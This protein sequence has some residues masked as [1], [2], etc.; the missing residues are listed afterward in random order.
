[1]PER[2]RSIFGLPPVLGKF[3]SPAT[4][5]RLGVGLGDHVHTRVRAVPMG[6]SWATYVVQQAHLHA[7]RGCS[8]DA[9]YLVD[10][11]PA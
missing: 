4:R 7:L 11:L 6:W 10:K 5:A 8:P 2:L 9:G 1:M 3:L